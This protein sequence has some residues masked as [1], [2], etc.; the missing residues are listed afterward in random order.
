MLT[1]AMLPVQLSSSAMVRAVVPVFFTWNES[2]TLVRL[3]SRF[4]PTPEVG[5]G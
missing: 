3:G 4:V 5:Y 1:Q 2:T